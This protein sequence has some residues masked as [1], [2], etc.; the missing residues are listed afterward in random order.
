MLHVDHDWPFFF[1]SFERAK[2]NMNMNIAKKLL[3]SFQL[4]NSSEGNGNLVD[5]VDPSV[6]ISPAHG[7]I[8]SLNK[9]LNIRSDQSCFDHLSWS[10]SS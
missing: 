4:E 9:R 6:R 2:A 5:P 3:T 7:R 1:S 10:F 8:S